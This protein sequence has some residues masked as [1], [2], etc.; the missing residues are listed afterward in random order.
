MGDTNPLSYRC[1]LFNEN[2]ALSKCVYS[3]DDPHTRSSQF[4]IKMEEEGKIAERQRESERERG[5]ESEC[6]WR[7]DTASVVKWTVRK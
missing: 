1:Y 7:K 4:Y 5:R 3:I 2:S 6:R